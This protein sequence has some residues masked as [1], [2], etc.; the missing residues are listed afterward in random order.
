[1]K[2]NLNTILFAHAYVFFIWNEKNAHGYS[3]K[4]ITAADYKYNLVL[5]ANISPQTN[6]LL[7]S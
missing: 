1:M 2:N 6:S 3:A 7:N 5:S 4:T